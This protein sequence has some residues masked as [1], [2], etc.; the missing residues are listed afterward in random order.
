MKKIF[1]ALV[2][3]VV[4]F[5][6][7]TT[8]EEP[9]KPQ[10][11]K[12]DK[13][14]LTAFSDGKP[15]LRELA[16]A[17][18]VSLGTAVNTRRLNNELYSR[19]LLNNFNYVSPENEMKWG[20][21]QPKQDEFRFSPGDKLVSF[22]EEHG[23]KVRGHALVWH[24]Q[25]PKW[26]EEESDW[27]REDL[28]AVMKKHIET[29][30]GHYKGK[31]YAWDVVN[32]AFDGSN[33][34]KTIFYKVIGKEYIKMAF[35]LAHAAD[36]DALLYY[37]DY[38]AEIV[39][40]KSSAIYEMMK[41]L[42][43][44]G[45]PVHGVGLQAHLIL[46]SNFPID[47]FKK[48]IKRFLDLG[49]KVDITELDIRIK[50]P[51]T[52]KLLIQQAEQY[53]KIM[54]AL[55]S[56]PECD[57][58]VVWGVSDKDSWIGYS[59]KGYDAAVLFDKQYLPKPAFFALRSVL[60]GESVESS[61]VPVPIE[62][63]QRRAIPSFIAKKAPHLPSIDGKNPGK[64]WDGGIRY[65]LGFNQLNVDDMRPPVDRK[66]LSGEWTVL[67]KG[68]TL[69]GM[70]KRVDDKTVTDVSQEWENDTVEVFFDLNGKFIQL[71]T[72]VGMDFS[73]NAYEG[74]QKAVWS[75]DGSILEFSVDMPDANIE[76]MVCGWNIA[77]A[78]NDG[79]PTRQYQ[80][81]PVAGQNDSY[82]G[83]NLATLTFEGTSP[84]PPEEPRVVMPFRAKKSSSVKVDGSY[85]DE[86][87]AKAVKYPFM[88][89]QMGTMDVRRNADP[90][91]LDGDW[92]VVYSGNKLYG[93]VKRIDDVTKTDAKDVWE[94]D[95]VEVFLEIDGSF[96]QMRTIVG[97]DWGKDKYT[98]AKKAVWSTD[99]SVL[100]FEIEL[101]K[102]PT[103]PGIIGFNIALSDND[104]TKTREA[105]LYPI[106]GF[107]D[108]WQGI[109]LAELE[110]IK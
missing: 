74:N 17:R 60:S 50:E 93:Y 102:S 59:F 28:I 79:G 2:L 77:L 38:S 12:Q 22:A 56:F 14:E 1:I 44:E 94:N 48:N 21:I 85:S 45:V 41:E 11:T 49:L 68:K 39:N 71:R 4:L 100:E 103:A 86:E 25:L 109:N 34:R 37:N 16:D 84:R 8:K 43:E 53:A 19:T 36:P 55:F 15:L 90:K 51:V 9:I 52:E 27:S 82:Q 58:F 67:Y 33:Y 96:T 24:S 31:V 6:C 47:S 78:D 110:F 62:D 99:G 35:E 91:D 5:G 75:S 54:E 88:Y 26:I 105:Q 13:P 23:M 32:E 73:E 87:W 64:E 76:A 81:Y 7:V 3:I 20:S 80:L 98:G 69:Y 101:P 72:I 83:L 92:G 30:A 106:Y 104:G 10:P 18:K 107:N 97:Q 42:V 29:V 63:L 95:C 70:L 46:E 40:A 57:T 89:N 65:S 66:D 108:S 61:E